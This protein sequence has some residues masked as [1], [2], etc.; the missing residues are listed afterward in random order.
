MKRNMASADRVIR[1]LIAVIIG[2]LYYFKLIEGT[3]AYVL[4]TLGAI[5]F[6]NRFHWIL[7]V[8]PS[9]WVQH[10]QNLLGS[11]YKVPLRV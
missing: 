9:F 7:S 3:L 1:M 10:L 5:F 6:V 2:I 8:V 4:L 11:H